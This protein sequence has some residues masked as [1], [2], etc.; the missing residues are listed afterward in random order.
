MANPYLLFTLLLEAGLDGISQKREV[1]PS[2]DHDVY[3]MTGEQLL[4]KGIRTIPAS[5][6]K[7]LENITHDLFV[8]KVLGEKCVAEFVKAKQHELREYNLHI[9]QWELDHYLI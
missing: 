7:A 8:S 3:K 9:S 4:R 5:L 2:V 1:P 6:E